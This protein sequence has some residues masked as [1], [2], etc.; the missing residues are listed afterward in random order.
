MAARLIGVKTLIDL[1]IAKFA[2]VRIRRQR[3]LL[4]AVGGTGLEWLAYRVPDTGLAHGPGGRQAAS[5]QAASRQAASR[6]AA[7][8]QA[9]SPQ[10]ASRQAA[11]SGDADV[12]YEAADRAG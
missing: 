9:A 6:Q 4:S 8:G 7:S 10:A 11:A 3:S 1:A 5:R 2:L 12:G